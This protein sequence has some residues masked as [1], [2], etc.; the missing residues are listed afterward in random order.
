MAGGDAQRDAITAALL[1]DIGKL[2]AIS[3]DRERW[4]RI[5]QEGRHRRIPRHQVEKELEEVTHAATGA[6]L[7]ALW[8]LP[9]GV[10]GAN[11]RPRAPLCSRQLSQHR[12][13]PH[14]Y[15]R[16]DEG[17]SVAACGHSADPHLPVD[18]GAAGSCTVTQSSETRFIAEMNAEARALGMDHTIYRSQRV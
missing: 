15:L 9:L 11:S 12:R 3:D 8:E 18:S 5:T 4:A 10:V 13:P 1:H 17:G 2:V 14:R 6:Y 16:S 7:L